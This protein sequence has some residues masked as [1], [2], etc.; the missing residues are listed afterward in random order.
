MHQQ[1][2]V[3]SEYV[4]FIPIANEICFNGF[5]PY[6]LSLGLAS[7]YVSDHVCILIVNQSASTLI[8]IYPPHVL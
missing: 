1:L 2:L 8:N 3:A 6:H 7:G 5:M 4:S